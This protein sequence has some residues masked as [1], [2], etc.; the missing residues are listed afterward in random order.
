MPLDQA[1]SAVAEQA[2][3]ARAAKLFAA[4]RA[5][6]AAGETLAGAL[7]RW[8]RTFSDLYRGLV[9]VAAETGNLPDVLTRL[10][11]Y[12]DARQAQKQQFTLALVYPVLVTVIAFAV[13]VRP[14]GLRR[15]ADRRRLPAEP[16][17]AALA[18]AGADRAVRFPARDGVVLARG[19]GRGDR[20]VDAREPARGVSSAL[21]AGAAARARRGPARRRRG[22]RAFREHAG[23]P[24]RQRRAA[25]A[26]ARR[27]ARRRLG[28]AAQGGGGHGRRCSCAKA[29]RWRGR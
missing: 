17:D 6:V 2:D 7:A 13:I 5:Q 28:A 18:H 19:R 14:A 22:H 24:H 27:R 20:R 25:A 29:C 16:A 8:P 9:A 1:L 11:D 15:A 10:A 26:L 4:A 3:D 21:A 12:L 23:D